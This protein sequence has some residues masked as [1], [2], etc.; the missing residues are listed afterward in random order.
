A[1]LNVPGYLG[2][3]RIVRGYPYFGQRFRL[4]DFFSVLFG[5]E[6]AQQKVSQFRFP[7]EI[8]FTDLFT[9]EARVAPDDA[10]V[11]PALAKSAKFSFAFIGYKSDSADVDGGLALNLPVDR[12]HARQATEGR[13]IAISFSG[14]HGFAAQGGLVGFAEQ[15][16]SAAIQSGVT[17]SQ[18]ILGAEN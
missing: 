2:K 12:L 5:K 9:L 4:E 17:R 13:V 11:S 6:L 18:T 1:L 7:L 15:L 16:M 10:A 8:Y 3:Y 14:S